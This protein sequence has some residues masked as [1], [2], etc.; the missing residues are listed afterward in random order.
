MV[1]GTLAIY[2]RLRQWWIR[3]TAVV[4]GAILFIAFLL[5]LTSW[6]LN[7]STEEPQSLI[8]SGSNL[9]DLTLI[10]NADEKGAVCLDG[11][12]PGY[13]LQRGFGS[14]SDSWVLHLESGGWCDSAD[15]CSYRQGTPLGSSH[16]MELQASFVGIL[17]QAPSENPDFYNWNRVKI[18]YCD[19]ASFSGDTE[20]QAKSG[21]KLFFRG[22]RIWEA[23]MEELLSEGLG[24]AKQA[25]LT[26]CSAGG[27]AI[28]IHCDSF[29]ALMPKEANVKCLG[30]AS[31]FLDVKDVSGKRTMQSFYKEVVR[32]Q[33]VGKNLPADCTKRTEPSQCFFPHELIKTIKTPL[34]ILNSAYDYW[35]IQNVLVPEDSDPRGHWLRC[36]KNIHNCHPNQIEILQG[37]RT[38]LLH[39]LS[40]FQHK[41]DAGMFINSCFV[42]C[43]TMSNVTWHSPK[44]PKI[45]NR[46][47]AEAVGD[48][49]FG[50]REAIY[51]DCPYPCNPTCYHRNF[52]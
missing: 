42:H 52:N 15:S 19:G 12:R 13:H 40:E 43:Q 37:F 31:F 51:V 20:V 7:P 44:S 46:T 38:S 39:T 22:Q 9:V 50:R 3:V 6:F 2:H 1:T 14:G 26:G 18:R 30:D 10:R 4:S 48:W 29:R 27:L 49:Y 32:L 25:F 34:F 41:K 16:Y 5:T 45:N 17:S 33:N 23:I 35:Q 21:R 28:Y 8:P 24:K 47:I 11:S 36:K